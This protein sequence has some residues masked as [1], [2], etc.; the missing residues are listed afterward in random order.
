[1]KIDDEY[2]FREERAEDLRRRDRER[3]PRARSRSARRD[4]AGRD[5]LHIRLV[6]R[7]A[8][9]RDGA[10]DAEPA[11]NPAVIATPSPRDSNA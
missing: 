9:A 10:P 3:E 8:A 2:R 6:E 5:A 4:L 7:K 11:E 1:M